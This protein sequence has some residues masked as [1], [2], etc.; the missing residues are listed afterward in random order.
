MAVKPNLLRSLLA[1]FRIDL[2]WFSSLL[3]L[4]DSPH[5]ISIQRP[6]ILHYKLEKKGNDAYVHPTFVVLIFLKLIQL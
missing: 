5:W 6:T 2:F 3:S 4:K 1:L